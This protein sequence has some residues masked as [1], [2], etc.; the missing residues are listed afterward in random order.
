[1]ERRGAPRLVVNPGVVSIIE[2]SF[3]LTFASQSQLQANFFIRRIQAD[4]AIKMISPPLGENTAMQ[5]N[6]GEGKSSVVLPISA[7]TLADGDKLVRVIVPK[8]LTVQMF[9]LLVDR[10]G[11]L[12]NRPIYYLPFSRSLTNRYS[13]QQFKSLRELLSECMRDR[14]ILVVQPEHVLSLKL[15][16]VQGQLPRYLRNGDSVNSESDKFGVLGNQASG[17]AFMK[18]QRWVQS[19]S[20]DILDES[21]EVLH[22]RFQLIYTIGLQQH[23]E[24]YPD[25]WTITQ[26]V[27]RLAKKHVLSLS[28]GLPD[29][30]EYELGPSGSFP[31]I[32][33]LRA[34][35]VRQHLISLVV[36]DVM[37]GHLPSLSFRDIDG[38]RGLRDAVR[39]F[40]SSKDVFQPTVRMVEEYAQKSVLWDGLLLLRGLFAY[41]ILLF[42]LAE[43]RWRV[44]Y[45]LSP[46]RTLLAVPYRAKDVPAPTAEF[47][48]PDIAIVLTCLSYYYGGLT[49]EQLRASF[50][51]LQEQDDPSLEYSNW[52]QDYD[53]ASVPECIQDLSN[54][55]TKSSEQW[56]KYLFPLFAR[57]QGA[58]DFYL[59]RVVFPREAK[60]FPQ[61]LAASSWDLAERREHPIT[62]E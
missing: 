38:N 59:S 10:L 15:I 56:D 7:V 12:V 53:P 48:H 26:Q 57:N 39:A 34:S 31:R 42:A 45:G 61:K 27:L 20:R 46:T 33:I 25:R 22:P 55:N 52:L 17:G 24:G 43:R 13:R 50:E 54:V 58:V 23:M 18:L 51:T 11:G 21:D 28:H 6:M 3:V 40:I 30:I 9:R 35:D 44:D 60:E 14:G 4:V 32:R 5:V 2:C 1:M 37:D 8:A 41:N 36:D 49:E 29:A 47:G 19:Y 62:G 16:S